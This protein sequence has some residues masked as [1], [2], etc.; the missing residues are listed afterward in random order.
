MPIVSER[1]SFLSLASLKNAQRAWAART[2]RAVD[3]VGYVRGLD[4]NLMVPLC[5]ESVRDFARGSGGEL[6]ARRQ[7]GRAKLDV[8]PR[9]TDLERG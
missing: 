9:L 7:S 5:E 3:A 8:R 6:K 4:I 1:E 2:D